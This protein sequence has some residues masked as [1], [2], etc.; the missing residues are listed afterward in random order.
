MIARMKDKIPVIRQKDSQ[1]QL[2]ENSLVIDI[3]PPR[4]SFALTLPLNN[5]PIPLNQSP[6]KETPSL[7]PAGIAA[8]IDK[9]N[10]WAKRNS[11]TER[12][13]RK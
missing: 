1:S 4:L 11:V 8:A 3:N 12:L 13:M 5:C 9:I 7:T 10:E 6:I 2:V